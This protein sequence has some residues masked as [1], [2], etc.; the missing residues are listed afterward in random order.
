[1]VGLA[2]IGLSISEAANLAVSTFE[3]PI[4]PAW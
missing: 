3:S 4:Q 2:L 1:M